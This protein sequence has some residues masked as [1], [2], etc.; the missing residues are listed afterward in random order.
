MG[1]ARSFQFAEQLTAAFT[2]AGWTVTHD[3]DPIYSQAPGLRLATDSSKMPESAK[4]VAHA[5]SEVG[6]PF[7]PDR[8]SVA[9]KEDWYLVVGRL[10]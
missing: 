2:E 4:L 9:D 8:L 10:T 1:D 3:L 5:L 7:T 6:V